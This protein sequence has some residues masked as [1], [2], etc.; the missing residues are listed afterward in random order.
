METQNPNQSSRPNQQNPNQKLKIWTYYYGSE[1]G[2][3][4]FLEEWYEILGTEPEG[5]EVRT[6]DGENA[7]YFTAEVPK[8]LVEKLNLEE[9][10]YVE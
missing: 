8:S 9:D 6:M 10:W 4:D 2:A 7:W 5:N 3:I 1:A